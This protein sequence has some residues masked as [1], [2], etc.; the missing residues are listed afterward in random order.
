MNRPTLYDFMESHAKE[1]H[2]SINFNL[3]PRRERQFLNE[4]FSVQRLGPVKDYPQ[5][6]VC[7][8]DWTY[9]VPGTTAYKFLEFA[10]AVHPELLQQA[11]ETVTDPVPLP[12]AQPGWEGK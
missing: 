8:V 3:Y 2:T 10:A 7:K 4:G 11:A 1:G 12:Y 6:H 9:A 5:Q